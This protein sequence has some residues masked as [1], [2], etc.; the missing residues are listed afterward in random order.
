MRLH[1]E[2][3]VAIFDPTQVI[4][5]PMKTIAIALAAGIL[6]SLGIWAAVYWSV[7]RRRP[8]PDGNGDDA[9][10]PIDEQS[11]EQP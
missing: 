4:D 5:I 9:A 2:P 6:L 3:G 1:F 8:T 10:Q 11:P 7:K